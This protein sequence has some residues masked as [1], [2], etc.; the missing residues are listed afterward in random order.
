MNFLV[1]PQDVDDMLD[2]VLQTE[3]PVLQEIREVCH[4]NDLP[5]IEVSPQQGKLLELLTK[6]ANPNRAIEI[7]TLG[8]YSTVCIARGLGEYG[9]VDTV[10]YERKHWEV[11]CGNVFR[12]GL[13]DKITCHQADALEWLENLRGLR[14]DFFFIDADKERNEDYLRW[15]IDHG[16]TGSTIIVDNVI[17]EGRVMDP[18]R[19]EKQQFVNY[20]GSLIHEGR[21]S[22]TIVQTVG[23]KT[24]DGFLLG[25][26]L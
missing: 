26:K 22:A 2:V 21:L 4:A 7:G 25:R 10:E 1:S 3:D 6:M 13:Q 24:W 9:H 20:V 15:A 19:S 17:R 16:D 11:A 14:P 23:G 12:S 18:N 5:T 8:G